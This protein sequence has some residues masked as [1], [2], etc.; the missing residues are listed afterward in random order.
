MLHPSIGVRSVP[1]LSNQLLLQIE[2]GQIHAAVISKPEVLP[3]SLSFSKITTEDLVLLAAESSEDLPA[4]E[5]LQSQPFIR[6]NRDAVVGRQIEAWLQNNGIVV[7]DVME[8][9]GLEA[10]S[11]MVAAGFGI[12]V[13]PNRCI[14]ESDHL[15]L[16]RKPLGD[17]SPS[18]LLGLVSSIY[19]PKAMVT[20]AVEA[21]LSKAVSIGEF[22]IKS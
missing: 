16:T 22:N 7:N 18:R 10:I 11:S 8:L 19:S 1:D 15:P 9:E 3:K 17:D 13:V 12:S 5:L 6:F 2:R 4:M 14:V 21:A 20:K